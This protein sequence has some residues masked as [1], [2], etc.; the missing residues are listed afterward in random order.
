MRLSFKYE[1]SLFF[2]LTNNLF[3]IVLNEG[4]PL[5]TRFTNHSINIDNF[6]AQIYQSF[7]LDLLSIGKHAVHNFS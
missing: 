1:V 6:E 2:D 5:Q 4:R 7:V 3:L